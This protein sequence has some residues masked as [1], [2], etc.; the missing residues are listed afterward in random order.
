MVSETGSASRMLRHCSPNAAYAT[1]NGRTPT[2]FEL[3]IV[4]SLHC[5]VGRSSLPPPRPPELR[6]SLDCDRC[7]VLQSTMAT[8]FE[9]EEA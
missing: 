7:V 4:E 8:D 2:R 9:A 1:N 6:H 3:S 5:L